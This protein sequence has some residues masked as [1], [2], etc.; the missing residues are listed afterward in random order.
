MNA[1]LFEYFAPLSLVQRHTLVLVQV[2]RNNVNRQCIFLRT[3]DKQILLT[4]LVSSCARKKRMNSDRTAH[5][6][7]TE[8]V[9]DIIAPRHRFDLMYL[10]SD[11]SYC[12][13]TVLR[14]GAT[15]RTKSDR[16]YL[17]D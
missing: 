11:G 6:S 2:W 7:M 4:K 3:R 17:E 1:A 8:N 16:Q 10:D 12:V 13:K 5:R 9:S 14:I 15:F